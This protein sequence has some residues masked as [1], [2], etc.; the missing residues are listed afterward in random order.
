MEIARGTG[1]ILHGGTIPWRIAGEIIGETSEMFLR[2]PGGNIEIPEKQSIKLSEVIFQT[3]YCSSLH[4][5]DV[6]S[7][8]AI[9]SKSRKIFMNTFQQH[10]ISYGIP[11]EIHKEHP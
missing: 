9:F 1:G 4:K 2:I 10:R 3:I 5:I 8:K 6:G 7:T 11:E